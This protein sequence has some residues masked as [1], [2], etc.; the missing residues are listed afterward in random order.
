M[1]RRG[2]IGRLSRL[3]VQ[4][5]RLLVGGRL[6]GCVA[7]PFR[8]GFGL[9]LA[10]VVFLSR[11]RLLIGGLCRGLGLG[12]RLRFCALVLVLVPGPILVLVLALVHG[13]RLL[14]MGG[15]RPR[16]VGEVHFGRSMLVFP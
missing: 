4:G 1:G 7:R 2:G 6:G 12:V 15:A 5:C 8:I 9:G 3:L 14:L 11:G 13:T 16:L 10:L